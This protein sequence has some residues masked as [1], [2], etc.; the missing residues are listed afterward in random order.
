MRI[1]SD[2]TSGFG[3]WMVDGHPQSIQFSRSFWE[4]ILPAL[5]SDF[6]RLPWGGPEIGGVLFGNREPAG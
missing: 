2:V 4:D 5:M 1:Q 6:L 3:E